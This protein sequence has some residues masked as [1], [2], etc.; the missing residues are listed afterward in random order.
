MGYTWRNKRLGFDNIANGSATGV[1]FHNAGASYGEKTSQQSRDR[2]V[3]SD[4]GT[5]TSLIS[6]VNVE[7]PM[8][9]TS[10]GAVSDS[11]LSGHNPANPTSIVD[12]TPTSA[13]TPGYTSETSWTTVQAERVGWTSAIFP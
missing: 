6:A 12:I 7:L 1:E 8:V 11:N 4:S 5:N 9:G 3:T 10:T 13:T 2:L